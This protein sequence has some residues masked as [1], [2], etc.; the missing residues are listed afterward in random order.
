MLATTWLAVAASV[1]PWPTQ[2]PAIAK[3]AGTPA[4]VPALE[5][6]VQDGDSPLT[7]LP[8]AFSFPLDDFQL[9]SLRALHDGQSVVVSAPTGS[10]KTVCGELGCYLALYAKS[11][12]II[13]YAHRRSLWACLELAA[14]LT[15]PRLA[16][17]VSRP[18]APR[19]SVLSTPLPS[20]RSRIK[21]LATSN[22]S[23]AG[24]ASGC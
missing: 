5:Q 13:A 6:A 14:R 2:H 24:R 8:E 7:L 21:S 17:V 12:Y 15:F 4:I 10:G 11:E 18:A 20:R 16:P 19:A 9:D 22:G 23:L 3:L 1:T